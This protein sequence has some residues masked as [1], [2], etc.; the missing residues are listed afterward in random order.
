MEKNPKKR[1]LRLNQ[2]PGA[3]CRRFPFRNINRPTPSLPT[4]SSTMSND[5]VWAC[6]RSNSCFSH[7]QRGRNGTGK[8][9]RVPR[10]LPRQPPSRRARRDLLYLADRSVNA[11]S[12]RRRARTACLW[13]RGGLHL[14]HTRRLRAQFTKE[15]NNIMGLHT[16]KYSSLV[17]LASVFPPA[18]RGCCAEQSPTGR[19]AQTGTCHTAG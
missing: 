14:L 15:A 16:R 1:L 5:L 8:R 12:G 13:G 18:T 7:T 9:V 4:H 19:S 2:Y 3:A 11:P 17:R 10:G 6:V